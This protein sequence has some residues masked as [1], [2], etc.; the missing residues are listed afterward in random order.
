MSPAQ[1]Y[2]A[3]HGLPPV[4]QERDVFAWWAKY[5]A[6]TPC[7]RSR[8]EVPEEVACTIADWEDERSGVLHTREEQAA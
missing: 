1:A 8:I 4:V 7:I 2:A 6:K 3:S 5:Q